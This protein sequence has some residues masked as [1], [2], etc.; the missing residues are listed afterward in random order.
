MEANGRMFM[1]AGM[2]H[3][4]RSADLSARLHKH[5]VMGWPVEL[6]NELKIT[7]LKTLK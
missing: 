1:M 2:I 3:D 4:L 5:N 7:E 6:M